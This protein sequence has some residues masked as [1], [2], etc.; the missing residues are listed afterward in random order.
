LDRQ[1]SNDSG[2]KKLTKAEGIGRMAAAGARD[3]DAT[4]HK[5]SGDACQDA[6]HCHRPRKHPAEKLRGHHEGDD[7]PK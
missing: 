3:V 7:H 6:D 2:T 5:N 4:A 1:A